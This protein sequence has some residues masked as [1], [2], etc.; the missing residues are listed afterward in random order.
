[1]HRGGM[2]RI[3]SSFNCSHQSSRDVGLVKCRHATAHDNARGSPLICGVGEAKH[4]VMHIVGLKSGDR[5][6]DELGFWLAQFVQ[7]TF[8]PPA[9]EE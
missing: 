3:L 8:C 7:D 6:H 4:E 5:P 1:M 2:G 9:R